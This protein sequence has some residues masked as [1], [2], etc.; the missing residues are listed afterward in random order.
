MATKHTTTHSSGVTATRGSKNR[1]Y[2]HA[3]WA[4]ETVAHQKARIQEQVAYYEKTELTFRKLMVA[5]GGWS[6]VWGSVRGDHFTQDMAEKYMNQYAQRA[7]DEKAKLEG[8]FQDSTPF[9]LGWCSRK[10]LADKLAS[11]NTAK[12]WLCEITE[13]VTI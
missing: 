4:I 9:V 11:Q 5:G 2:T 12:G 8:H 1:V 13:A 3:V 7:K 10:D 6:N